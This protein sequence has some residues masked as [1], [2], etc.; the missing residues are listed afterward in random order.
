MPSATA[1]AAAEGLP[2][3]ISHHLLT[4]DDLASLS[5][6][7]LFQ[8]AAILRAAADMMAY[9]RHAGLLEDISGVLVSLA[10]DARAVAEARKPTNCTEADWRGW[11]IAAH[12]AFASEPLSDIAAKA[13]LAAAVERYAP[14][15]R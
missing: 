15:I 13:A 3:D 6:A 10:S 9:S 1:L 12:A 11:L 8:V 14:A 5:H 7:D 2:I 4:M